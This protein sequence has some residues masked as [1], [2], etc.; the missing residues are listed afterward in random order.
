MPANQFHRRVVLPIRLSV[1]LLTYLS[2]YLSVYLSICLSVYMLP[3]YMFTC[4]S[5]YLSVRLSIF[6]TYMYL[7]VYL[8]VFYLSIR[9]S[10]YLSR[11][12]CFS[13]HRCLSFN[14]LHVHKGIAILLRLEVLFVTIFIKTFIHLM[15]CSQYLPKQGGFHCD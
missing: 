5:V 1:F 10:F 9:L 6:F 3:N 2:V 4:L 11:P 7:S 15:N 8:S 13:T 14:G 12:I